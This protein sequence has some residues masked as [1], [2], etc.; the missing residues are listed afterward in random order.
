[1]ALAVGTNESTVTC[2]LPNFTTW[3]CNSDAP[4][5]CEDF[6]LSW[7]CLS[8]SCVT[9]SFVIFPTLCILLVSHILYLCFSK[10]E[11]V[12][13][14][15]FLYYI[16]QG[17]CV[18]MM[19]SALACIVENAMEKLWIA[20]LNYAVF[21]VS[22]LT[23]TF[24]NYRSKLL[25]LNISQFVFTVIFILLYGLLLF[26]F[27]SMIKLSAD[28]QLTMQLVVCVLLSMFL[29]AQLASFG[30]NAALYRRRLDSTN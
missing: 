8:R 27:G 25:L 28:F 29:C 2:T 10:K 9:E 21:T 18:C 7:E 16:T 24:T 15:I 17:I 1:M 4:E 11:T 22:V 30:V 5:V 26:L 12:H 23:L 13:S 14:N 3:L 20:C 19:L 6:C